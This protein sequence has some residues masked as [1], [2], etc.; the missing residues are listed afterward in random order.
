MEYGMIGWL[1]LEGSS[2]EVIGPE[3][4]QA[5]E[6]ILECYYLTQDF[7]SE[8]KYGTALDSTVIEQ[9]E[10]YEGFDFDNVW[11]MREQGG[12]KLPYLKVFDEITTDDFS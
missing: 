4:P 10:S 1:Y 2:N 12:H 3:T 11:E 6:C 8:N 9:Q 7:I 5:K